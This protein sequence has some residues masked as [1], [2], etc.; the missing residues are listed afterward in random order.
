[1]MDMG[2]L[3]G[4]VAASRPSHAAQPRYVQFR[5]LQS[6]LDDTLEP[7]LRTTRDFSGK[8]S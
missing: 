7:A 1:M 4:C 8:T 3:P 2:F 5:V 6:H